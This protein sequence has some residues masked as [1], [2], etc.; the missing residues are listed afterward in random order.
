MKRGSPYKGHAPWKKREPPQVSY[1]KDMLCFD[2]YFGVE[3][4][5]VCANILVSLCLFLLCLFMYIEM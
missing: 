4:V 2:S 5:R 3:V 1:L